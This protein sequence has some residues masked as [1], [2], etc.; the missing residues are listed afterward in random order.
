MSKPLFIHGLFRSGSTYLFDKLRTDEHLHCYYE[1]FHHVIDSLD[2]MDID[3]WSHSE[4]TSRRMNHPSLTRPHFFEYLQSFDEGIIKFFDKSLSYDRF[5]IGDEADF[6]PEKNYLDHL[7]QTSPEGCTPVFQLNRSTF[8]LKNFVDAYPDSTHF[9]LLRNQRSQFQSYINSG[10]IFLIINL[11]IGA[12]LIEK[13]HKL[14]I[15]IPWFK[16]ALFVK[17]QAFY[18]RWLSSVTLSDHYKLFLYL[19]SRSLKNA[20]DAGCKILDMENITREELSALFSKELSFYNN[21]NDFYM[22]SSSRFLLTNKEVLAA[23][24][25]FSGES[26]VMSDVF[27]RRIEYCD[28]RNVDFSPRLRLRFF[29]SFLRILYSRVRNK[30]KFKVW[31]KVKSLLCRAFGLIRKFLPRAIAILRRVFRR[32]IGVLRRAFR[33]LVILMKLVE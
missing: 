29:W 31:Y 32:V 22:K 14:P 27:G 33:R 2:Q 24:Q 7:I 26:V 5:W 19:W 11:I 20:V 1:P 30:L 6:G 4:K 18:S 3:I 17:E 12:R 13:G 21:F 9:F 23:E 25:G 16:H 8:R 28:G 10:P 15:S